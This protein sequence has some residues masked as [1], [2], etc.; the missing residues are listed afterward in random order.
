MPN[1]FYLYV[2]FQKADKGYK[3]F[4]LDQSVGLC[5]T[6]LVLTCTKSVTDTAGR[7]IELHVIA[8]PVSPSLKPKGFIHWV[9][10]P[11]EI[12]IRLYERL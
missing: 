11:I 2:Y 3:R 7:V 1:E 8:Q 6:G 9:S 12:E 10:K 4:A 5:H